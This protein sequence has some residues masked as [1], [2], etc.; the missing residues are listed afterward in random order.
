MIYIVSMKGNYI[1]I[2]ACVLVLISSCTIDSAHSGRIKG[3]EARSTDEL[4]N[5]GMPDVS[6]SGDTCTA[7]MSEFP[8]V[9]RRWA[10]T[11]VEPKYGKVLSARWL[12]PYQVEMTTDKGYIWTYGD[13]L[14][15]KKVYGQHALY[16]SLMYR[17][18]IEQRVEHLMATDSAYRQIA[19]VA[20]RLVHEIEYDWA[21]ISGYNGKFVPSPHKRQAVC[22]GYV[23]EFTEALQ[24]LAC[25]SSV[26]KWTG[27]NHAWNVLELTDG[28]TLYADLCW[29]DGEIP[30]ART[31]K[32][33][34]TEE[35]NWMN[36]T[37]DTEEFLY[38]NVGFSSGM[39]CHVY[40]ERACERD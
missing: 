10:S 29:F 20:M 22:E 4:G 13:S 37:F 26:E 16:Q 23:V 6:V 14:S 15:L 21:A 24:D 25:V 2:V 28:R 18:Q 38:S 1:W 8:M 32:T 12:N 17:H 39:F 33:S 30:D 3:R 34:E 19:E 7:D 35:Y 36:L 11:E 31:G 9:V 27:A 40:G 5:E